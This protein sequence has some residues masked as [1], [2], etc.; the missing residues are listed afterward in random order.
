LAALTR[1]RTPALGRAKSAI[2]TSER[3]H[4][5]IT[6]RDLAKLAA[7]AVDDRNARFARR[8][9][10]RVYDKRAICI[11]LCQGAALHYVDG[12]NGVKDFDVWTFYAAH[13]AGNFPPRWHTLVDFGESRF[14][15]RRREP[16]GR[17][18]EGRRVDLFGRSLAER[19]RVD[20]VDALTR[21]LTAGRTQSARELAE[22][23][24]VILDP[25]QLRG[26]VVWP[27]RKRR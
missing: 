27:L 2:P 6:K 3:S 11:A 8:P 12:E 10:W 26:T 7:I 9:R 4:E 15:R 24:V 17:S 5:R 16:D 22:K 25:P 20:A 1:S 13:P 19:P 21:Y 18:L 14:G 23:A